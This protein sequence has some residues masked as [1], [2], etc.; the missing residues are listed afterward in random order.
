MSS[1]LKVISINSVS[2]AVQNHGELRKTL[3]DHLQSKTQA[4]ENMS[5]QLDDQD[6]NN[7]DLK[8]DLSKARKK[9]VSN[10][11]HNLFD[12]LRVYDVHK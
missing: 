6:K 1:K 12:I 2:R 4:M 7:S 8:D 11:P 3:E 5:K 9:L 10:P